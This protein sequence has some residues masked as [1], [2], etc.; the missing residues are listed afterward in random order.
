MLRFLAKHLFNVDT[1]SVKHSVQK[2]A[3][4]SHPVYFS[5]PE[6]WEQRAQMLQNMAARTAYVK[7]PRKAEV[8]GIR[9]ETVR[10]PTLSPGAVEKLIR[11]MVSNIGLRRD[12]VRSAIRRRREQIEQLDLEHEQQAKHFAEA[13]TQAETGRRRPAAPLP[14][15]RAGREDHRGGLPLP[16]ALQAAD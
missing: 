12:D 11:R 6:Q 10:Y 5:L 14:L 15:H 13:L 1:L 2:G 4:R 3:E 16:R 8:A 7:R 9:T